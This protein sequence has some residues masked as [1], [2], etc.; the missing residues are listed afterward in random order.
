M[1]QRVI[2]VHFENVRML[3]LLNHSGHI[4]CDPRTIFKVTLMSAVT[5]RIVSLLRFL[6]QTVFILAQLAK[7]VCPLSGLATGM[8]MSRHSARQDNNGRAHHSVHGGVQPVANCAHDKFFQHFCPPSLDISGKV[9]IFQAPSGSFL[10]ITLCNYLCPTVHT[11]GTGMAASFFA[12]FN[13]H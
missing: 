12:K 2:F 6:L 8:V 7:P 11:L 13:S 4:R 3:G 9:A 5:A 10:L 1:G